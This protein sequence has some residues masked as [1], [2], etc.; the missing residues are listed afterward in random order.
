MSFL[1]TTSIMIIHSPS[2]SKKAK[3]VSSYRPFL[4]LTFLL[5]RTL[6][7]LLLA[8]TLSKFCNTWNRKVNKLKLFTPNNCPDVTF[9]NSK[10][11]HSREVKYLGLLLNKKLN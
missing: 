3:L 6:N 4:L 8:I 9:N 1:L 5:L 10:M 11:L 2:Y 7:T